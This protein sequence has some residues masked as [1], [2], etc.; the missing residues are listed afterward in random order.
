[1]TYNLKIGNQKEATFLFSVDNIAD[2]VSQGRVLNACRKIHADLFHGDPSTA[3]SFNHLFSLSDPS[4]K[5]D[6][7]EIRTSKPAGNKHSLTKLS[8]VLG[9]KK[10]P[11]AYQSNRK[12]YNLVKI[13]NKISFS[14]VLGILEGIPIIGSVIGAIHF[15]VR[16][17]LIIASY[18]H[19]RQASVAYIKNE[20]GTAELENAQKVYAAMIDFATHLYYLGGSA[21]SIIPGRKPLTRLVQGII[22]NRRTPAQPQPMSQKNI[23][24]ELT[25]TI[26]TSIS[27]IKQHREKTVKYRK[28]ELPVPPPCL[29]PRFPKQKDLIEKIAPLQKKQ[30][31]ARNHKHNLELQQKT[32][33]EGTILSYLSPEDLRSKTERS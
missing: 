11:T 9:E 26:N 28:S 21:L 18:N 3:K 17:H 5:I 33:I 7:Q 14:A 16:R 8:R 6:V 1:M 13:E 23:D 24:Q 32:K 10:I 30:I 27:N 15:L 31:R 29:L 22:Y 19:L 25:E 20:N 4:S 12:F 2:D